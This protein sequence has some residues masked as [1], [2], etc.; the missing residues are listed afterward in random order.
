MKVP[1]PTLHLKL[2]LKPAKPTLHLKLN[3]KPAKPTLNLKPATTVMGL[4]APSA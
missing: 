2:N 3:L 4:G 1:K